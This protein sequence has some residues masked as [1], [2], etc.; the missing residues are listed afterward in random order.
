[1]G[2]NEF[3]NF[4][5]AWQKLDLLILTNIGGWTYLDCSNSDDGIFPRISVTFTIAVVHTCMWIQTLARRI[6][7]L[8]VEIIKNLSIFL[9]LL[10]QPRSIL[11]SSPMY[12]DVRNYIA[13]SNFAIITVKISLNRWFAK[14]CMADIKY[15][16]CYSYTIYIP[17]T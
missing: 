3:G 11:F 12:W 7:I 8:N 15:Y 4:C 10:H 1:M 13:Y 17:S 2:K 6:I 9:G 5:H 14:L 16:M